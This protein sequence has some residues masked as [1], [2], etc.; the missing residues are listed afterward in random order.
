ME[1][2]GNRLV[3]NLDNLRDFDKFELHDLVMSTPAKVIPAM[4]KALNELVR[5]L[6]LHLSVAVPAVPC[7]IAPLPC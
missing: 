7:T 2:H 3:V 4:E 1:R 5:Q 6:P